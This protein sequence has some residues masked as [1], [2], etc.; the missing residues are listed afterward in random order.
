MKSKK[1]ELILGELQK[2]AR[3][4]RGKLTTTAVVKAAKSSTSVMH[5]RFTWDDTKAAVAYRHWQAEKLLRQFWVVEPVSRHEIPLYI[6]VESDRRSK[7]GGYR[8]WEDI[9]ADPERRQ[10][11]VGQALVELEQIERR[12]GALEELRGVFRAIAR[13]RAKL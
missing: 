9:L 3:Q 5:K 4:H 13:A 11:F 1:A 6:A 2:I 12:Y 7:G 8:R 10:E